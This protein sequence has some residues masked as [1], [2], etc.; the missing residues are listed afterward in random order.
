MLFG[1]LISPTWFSYLPLPI[2]NLANFS[3]AHMLLAGSWLAGHTCP[4]QPK[5]VILLKD[6]VWIVSFSSRIIHGKYAT[7]FTDLFHY[8]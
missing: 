8:P 1:Q 4:T 2:K 3:V 7:A 6:F 5:L